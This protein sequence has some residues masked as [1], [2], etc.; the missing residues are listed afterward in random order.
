MM[1]ES[2]CGLN[3]FLGRWTRMVR[4]NECYYSG[5]VLHFPF[6]P[7]VRFVSGLEPTNQ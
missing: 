2:L 4:G 6:D 1:A 3:R 5:V 7:A